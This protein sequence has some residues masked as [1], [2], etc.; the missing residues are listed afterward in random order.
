MRIWI[1]SN[2][3]CLAIL[4]LFTS[5]IF[6]QAPTI[7]SFNPANGTIGT[8]VTITGTNLGSPTVLTIG[9]VAAIPVSNT[10]TS[11]VA[12]VMTGATSGVI[13]IT[14]AGGSVNS[15]SNFTVSPS[16]TPNA[17][18]GAN[19]VG[20]VGSVV[21]FG[22]SVS[23]SADGN[24]AIVGGNY[25]A[26][27]TGAAWVYT[28][29]GGVWT[30]QGNKL[31]GTGAVGNANQGQSVS[32]SAD[33][34]TAIV[35]GP[36]DNG[37]IGAAWIYTRSGGV[38]TQ[39]GNK[40]VGTGGIL[41]P[42]QGFSVSISADGN[43]ALVGAIYDNAAIGA[44]WVFTRTAG[45]WTQQGSK[46]VGIGSVGQSYQGVSVS[47]SADGN[48][49]IIGGNSD[50]TNIGAAWI[51]TRT[52]GVWTQQE[53]KLVGT[54]NVGQSF[55]GGSV[56]I[57]ADGNTAIVGGTGDNGGVGA[58]WVYIRSAGVWTQQGSKLLGTGTIG[59]NIKQGQSVTLSAD[60]NTA[61]VG[62]PSENNSN[63]GAALIYKRSGGIWSQQG[64]KIVGVEVI[65][66]SVF[67]VSSALSADGKT[68]IIGG[69][70]RN[71]SEGAA[72]VFSAPDISIGDRIWQDTNGDGIQD[73]AE[74]GIAGV[75]IQLVQGATV[76]ATA[77]TDASGNYL[78]TSTTGVSTASTIY[79]IATLTASSNYIIR[80]PNVIGGSKQA[81]LGTN[82]LTIANT[83]ANDE[84]DSDGLL[85]GNDAE[86][87]IT[88]GL[89]GTTDLSQD[90][91]F[92]PPGGGVGG[93]GGGGLES[94]S[95]GD[96]IVKRVYN[97]AIHNENGPVEYNSLAVVVPRSNQQVAMGAAPSS[98][99]LA[100]I[101]P[102]ISAQGFIAYNSSPK[103]LT[104]IT[105]AKEVL[106]FDFT[107]NKEVKAVAFAT[108]TLGE[109]Y[110]HTKPI[111]DRLKGATLVSVEN[112]KIQGL[113]FVKYTINNENGQ[114]EYAT[115][116]SVGTK[117]NRNN[118][119]FQS[120]W[121]TQDYLSDETMYNFQLWAGTSALVTDM[122]T[123]IL[124]KVQAIAPIA[125]IKPTYIPA[126]YVE[127]GKRE[128]QNINL[129]VKNATANTNGYFTLEDKSNEISA[130]AVVRTI[131]FTI[132]A[133]GK[134]NV[135]IPMDDKYQSVLT[136]Y[137]NGVVKDVVYMSDGAWT[138]DY[139]KATTTLNNFTVSNDSKRVYAADEYPLFRNV[140]LKAN[141][142]DF[143]S[144]VKLLR[145]GGTAA[146][147]SAYK[148]IKFTASGGYSLR[149]TLVKNGIVDYKNQYA[150]IVPLELGEK[151]YYLSLDQFVSEG[152]SAK[153]NANDITTVVFT[154]EVFTGK[155]N[156]ISTNLSNISFTKTDMNYL[157]SLE[158]KELQISP[159]P[160]TG[161]RF[162]C[163]FMS[164]KTAVLSLHVTDMNGKLIYSQSVNAVK[165]ENSVPV[166]L[167][168]KTT[169]IQIVSL[170]GPELKYNSKKL[171]IVN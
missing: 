146:D 105:N 123:D 13:S 87:A 15:I 59:T 169:G 158:S 50:N 132:N 168:N 134:S 9:G 20:T 1:C 16:Q 162:I 27:H 153:I 33:G 68:V 78:F 142:S 47:I 63:E 42:N 151:E 64:S 89:A 136:M 86:I 35:G 79:G 19:L 34:N 11:L 37:N 77:T 131:P 163:N 119:S 154:V 71:S 30:Q 28:R 145:G 101:M 73:L 88:T 65:G 117:A 45:I 23:I 72:W 25:D 56:S 52:A 97:K 171:V 90:C 10:G 102:N 140:S 31:V 103:D 115:S 46:L 38:W 96:A 157:N 80:V 84:T 144:I 141:S 130:S 62:A 143:V 127:S 121:L 29:T 55:Q 111:C 150:A 170:E 94:K 91:G 120:T 100:S 14:T 156:T 148:G 129:V 22:R 106:A 167:T 165:G 40:L 49:A 41:F 57:S 152:T 43:T 164:S 149:V 112:I 155:N 137:V 75:T 7:A 133:N 85:V 116:F 109:L 113:D 83:P 5:S 6:A 107:A 110:D 128:G 126:T 18:Q 93:G 39:Q 3:I 122:V 159:N 51:F 114:R 124:A 53:N 74:T 48:T 54:G 58:A 82:T 166:T 95:L 70:F 8:L 12:M 138:V 67:G 60:G 36:T 161:N 104:S 98:V 2:A 76:I 21:E 66:G 26:S 118:F 160:V 125:S 4:L 69:A 17:Q 81:A 135:I 44:A 61:I 147:M 92:A 139:N 99:T 108:K 32:L 24:T